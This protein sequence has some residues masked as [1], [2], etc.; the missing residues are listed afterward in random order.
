[1]AKPIRTQRVA[2]RI[3]KELSEILLY[4]VTDPRLEG[5]TVTDVV[6]DRELEYARVFVS[7]V[8]GSVREEEVLEGLTRAAGFL[9]F[10]LSQRIDLRAFPQLRFK[11]DP[12]AERAER[13]EELFA[14]LKEEEEDRADLQ[15]DHDS[16]G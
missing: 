2:E 6:V 16:Q 11:W 12:T 3:R 8:E 5:V 15:E 1:M 10:N 13:M 7:T 4:E 14:S 9:R